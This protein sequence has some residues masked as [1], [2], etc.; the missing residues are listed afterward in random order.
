M[1]DGF[2]ASLYQVF[3]VVQF[4]QKALHRRGIIDLVA[5]QR[6][7]LPTPIRL[8][9]VAMTVNVTLW[10]RE[11]PATSVAV[12]TKLVRAQGTRQQADASDHSR[13]PRRRAGAVGIAAPRP[14]PASV[15][16]RL[17]VRTSEWRYARA[18]GDAIARTGAT[19]S[20]TVTVVVRQLRC[21]R[22]ASI[23]VNVTEVAPGANNAG[24]LLDTA[25]APLQLSSPIG[26]A[27]AN[28]APDGLDCSMVIGAGTPLNVRSCQITNRHND[29]VGRGSA[30]SIG[31]RQHHCVD[32]W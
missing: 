2:F 30:K 26:I 3:G 16:E 7:R 15:A 20:T 17:T 19:R 8:S 24:A 10:L 22:A 18:C 1:A 28:G 21:C 23:A 31:D 29:C 11:F 27:I 4:H 13:P 12:S 25:T 32:A 9:I 5:D 14:D 6:T